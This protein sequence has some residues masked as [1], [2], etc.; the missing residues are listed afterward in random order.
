MSTINLLSNLGKHEIEKKCVR[1]IIEKKLEED[2][3]VNY[4]WLVTRIN[5][6]DWNLLD[7]F[8]KLCKYEYLKAIFDNAEKGCDEG[9]IYNL[10]NV[11][12]YI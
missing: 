8:Y 2:K 7:L 5:S 12:S 3:Q 9:P 6:V 1:K 10:S 11:T 4:R